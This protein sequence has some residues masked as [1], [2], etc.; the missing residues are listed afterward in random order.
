MHAF[1]VFWAGVGILTVKVLVR[2]AVYGFPTVDDL[3]ESWGKLL[4]GG[5]A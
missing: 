1:D 4:V 3:S 2:A 5:I